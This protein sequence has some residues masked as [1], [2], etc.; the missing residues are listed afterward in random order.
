LRT[1]YWRRRRENF[2]FK[3]SSNAVAV[4]GN[5]GMPLATRAKG[6]AHFELKI[7]QFAKFANICQGV[8]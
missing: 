8:I 7:S 5:W 2:F 6:P 4:L 1:S 3:N